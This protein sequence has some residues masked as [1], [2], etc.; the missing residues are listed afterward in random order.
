VKRGN[1][2]ST[3][4]KATDHTLELATESVQVEKKGTKGDSYQ[5]QEKGKEKQVKAD[6]ETEKRLQTRTEKGPQGGGSN[7]AARSA[8]KKSQKI[9]IKPL[10]SKKTSFRVF[11]ETQKQRKK[12][13]GQ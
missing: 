8:G 13:D 11:F 12:K 7:E 10:S 2:P 9:T 5:W 1:G 4:R 3:R 6:C